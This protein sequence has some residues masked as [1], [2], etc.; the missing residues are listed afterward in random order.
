[1]KKLIICLS[2]C[3][4]A[5]I[6]ASVVCAA[7]SVSPAIDVLAARHK[8][9]K[10]CVGTNTVSFY[11][12]D[13]SCR[14]GVTVA[15]LPTNGKL[16]LDGRDVAVG[17][18]IPEEEYGDLRYAPASGGT[19]TFTLMPSDGYDSVFVC[20][21]TSL[22][23]LNFAPTAEDAVCECIAGVQVHSALCAED[24]E[25]DEMTYS[26]VSGGKYG[27]VALSANGEFVYYP[28][29]GYYGRD[30]FV[31]CVSDKWGNTSENAEC[32]VTVKKNN[33]GT[34]YADMTGDSAHV[35]AVTLAESGVMT[36]KKI[37]TAMY[38]EPGRTVSRGEFLMMT[39]N[40]LGLDR[41]IGAEDTKTVYTDDADLSAELRGYV[42]AATRL[43]IIVGMPDGDGV[44]FDADAAVTVSDAANVIGRLNEKCDLGILA[45]VPTSAYI[46]DSMPRD[47]VSLLC[48]AGL[49]P[50]DEPTDVL[51][52]RDVAVMLCTMQNA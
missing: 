52:R 45:A 30:T 44:K 48:S 31:F 24:G 50:C 3:L 1:M 15:S 33:T 47:G 29:E 40:M 43:G 2:L 39:M 18:F 38:F 23:A 11:D 42:A 49:L 25:G 28:S 16:T 9:V 26:L 6:W 46:G 8:V 34:V 13:F 17:A 35:A 12:E 7:G 41:L 10:T 19:D 14:G 51:T 32:R 5:V 20:E 4:C 27:T 37:G 36:G 21:V 22:P